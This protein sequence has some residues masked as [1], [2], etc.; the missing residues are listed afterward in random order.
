MTELHNAPDY[1]FYL[2]TSM[3]GWEQ[4]NIWCSSEGCT[5][6]KKALYINFQNYVSIFCKAMI[7]KINDGGHGRYYVLPTSICSTTNNDLPMEDICSR[8]IC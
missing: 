6:K 5:S 2:L 1:R 4:F 8:L 3:L 7:G